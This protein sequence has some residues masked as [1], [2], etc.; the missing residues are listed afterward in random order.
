MPLLVRWPGK[1]TPGGVCPHPVGI[2]DIART[3]TSAAGVTPEWKMH[4]HD[5]A[6]LLKDPDREWKHPLLLEH[7]RWEFGSQTDR[8]TGPA[9]GNVPWWFSLRD[10][11]YQYIR[12]LVEGE[13]EELYDLDSDP[14]QQ[15]N[16]AIEPERRQLLRTFRQRLLEELR[17]TKA[18]MVDRLPRPK[19]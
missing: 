8:G 15:R 6:P 16:L 4:G 2:V 18:G 17:G 3:V 11:K 13:I 19:E 5:L 12:T 1:T 9:L 7:C 10:G 14:R